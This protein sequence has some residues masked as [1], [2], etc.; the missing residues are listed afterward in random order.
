[1]TVELQMGLV[2]LDGLVAMAG[3]WAMTT[4]AAVV[5]VMA[6]AVV[7]V[8]KELD[9]LHVHSPSSC[10]HRWQP[11]QLVSPVPHAQA[12]VY[13]GYWYLQHYPPGRYANRHTSGGDADR[14]S[15][16]IAEN[17]VAAV[18]VVDLD[19]TAVG[20]ASDWTARWAEDG[21]AEQT[22]DGACA[23]QNRFEGLVGLEVPQ[24]GLFPVVQSVQHRWYLV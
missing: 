7:V 4:V 20:R 22:P 13:H 1:V 8:S 2:R 15:N 19:V 14:Y 23:A 3:T 24:H 16:C 10:G 21:S 17:R 9:A 18:A 12:Q 5:M 11:V 6:V